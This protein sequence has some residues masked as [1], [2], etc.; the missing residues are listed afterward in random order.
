MTLEAMNTSKDRVRSLNCKAISKEWS[1]M[2][3]LKTAFNSLTR[4]LKIR[5]MWTWAVQLRP[6]YLMNTLVE[7]RVIQ[8]LEYSKNSTL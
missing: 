1:R 3:N 7:G 4:S 8:R 2:C 6:Q 5:N